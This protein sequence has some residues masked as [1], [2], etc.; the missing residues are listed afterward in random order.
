[1][2]RPNEVLRNDPVFLETVSM[3][4]EY[5][6]LAGHLLKKLM[7]NTRDESTIIDIKNEKGYR[8][9]VEE[10]LKSDDI[11][12]KV[13]L[14]L[15]YDAGLVNL[16]FG[17]MSNLVDVLAKKPTMA[18][19]TINK[20]TD[21][22]QAADLNYDKEVEDQI[23]KVLE[24]IIDEYNVEMTEITKEYAPEMYEHMISDPKFTEKQ[25]ML[26]QVIIDEVRN[27]GKRVLN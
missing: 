27:K 10:I 6:G 13:H 21:L 11:Y 1:M 24:R 15:Y 18:S 19:E 14:V 16:V 9:A 26:K 4:R 17:S 2:E 3:A 20:I 23:V 22:K 25:Q 7:L 8:L 12:E 5:P